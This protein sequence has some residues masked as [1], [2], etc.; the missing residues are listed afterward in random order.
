MKSPD[1]IAAGGSESQHQ[2]ALMAWCAMAAFCGLTAACDPLSYK[3]AGYAKRIAV[4]AKPSI[5]ERWLLG[6]L[7]WIHAIPNGGSR[8]ETKEIAVLNGAVMKQEGVKRGVHDVFLPFPNQGFSG[9]YIEM[10]VG[11]NKLSDEQKEFKTFIE[12]NKY[13]SA[14]CYSWIEAVNAVCNYLGLKCDLSK[15]SGG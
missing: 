7:R 3:V 13:G 4:E 8:G 14:V 5:N 11:K 6:M 15:M 10:K 2:Q 9:L 12:Q 1:E